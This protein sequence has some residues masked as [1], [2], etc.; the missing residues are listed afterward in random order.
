[1]L[2]ILPKFDAI[3]FLIDE[4]TSIVAYTD[5][6]TDVTNEKDEFFGEGRLMEMIKNANYLKPED[7]INN[8][9]LTW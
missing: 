2:D 5:G 1:M 3:E 9:V 4:P 7:T 6:A 8:I